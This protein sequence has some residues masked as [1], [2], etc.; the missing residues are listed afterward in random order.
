MPSNAL[1]DGE[2]DGLLAANGV[3]VVVAGNQVISL[4]SGKD[5]AT[6]EGLAAAVGGMLR[7]IRCL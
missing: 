2:V 4:E 3:A 7:V 6:S 1:S 5:A